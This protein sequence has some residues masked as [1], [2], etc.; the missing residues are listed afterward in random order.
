LSVFLLDRN[1]LEVFGNP[2]ETVR[3]QLERWRDQ[4]GSVNRG[5]YLAG[6]S[7]QR[8]N[9]QDLFCP[10]DPHGDHSPV[11]PVHPGEIVR[12]EIKP[13]RKGGQKVH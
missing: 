6:F 5:K 12:E 1:Y 11:I 4:C 13:T 7:G 8:E 3:E 10:G 2:S 9:V